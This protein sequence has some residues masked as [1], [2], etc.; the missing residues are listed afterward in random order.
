[1]SHS[2]DNDDYVLADNSAT[3]STVSRH[4]SFLDNDNIDSL[5]PRRRSRLERQSIS[6]IAISDILDPLSPTNENST[7]S[8]SVQHSIRSRANSIS[9]LKSPV[10]NGQP[11]EI[12]HKRVASYCFAFDIDGV[13]LKGPTLIPEAKK[14]IHMLNGNNKYNVIV[15]FIFVTNGGGYDER[16]RS[17]LLSEKL[18]TDIDEFQVVQGHTPMRSLTNKYKNVLVV[19]GLGDNCRQIGLKYGF[20]NVYT[21]SDIIHWNPSVTPYYKLTDDEEELALKDVDFSKINIDCVMIMADSRNWVVDQ[22]IILELLL[23]EKGVMGT[24]IDIK[25]DD[26]PAVIEKKL[27]KTQPDLYFAHS[28]FVWATDYNLTRYGMGALQVSLAA[29][30]KE[31]TNGL[32]LPC[33]RFGKPQRTTFDFCVDFLQDWRKEVLKHISFTTGKR[34]SSISNGNFINQKR[35]Q[36]ITSGTGFK[37]LSSQAA[38]TSIMDNSLDKFR[39]VNFKNNSQAAA[40]RNSVYEAIETEEDLDDLDDFSLDEDK[41]PLSPTA[42]LSPIDELFKKNDVTMEKINKITLEESDDGSASSDSD[43]SVTDPK[44]ALTINKT[45]IQIPPPTTVYFVG[46]TPESDIRFANLHHESWFSI[47]VETGVYQKGTT[48]KYEPKLIRENVLEAV[49]W[50][51]E[52]EHKKECEE[53]LKINNEDVLGV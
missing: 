31:H 23:S 46:D 9:L 14:A 18:E 4:K 49:E 15:P 17:K 21:V 30:Y 7:R 42:K 24:H 37:P 20:E 45:T 53:W 10:S 47:L 44:N 13:I 5:K 39:A 28:D 1:M 35:P 26:D 3:D 43:D 12:T 40:K 36:S 22:Q 19:G 33:K 11:L 41:N 29:L 16:L 52:N 48:P 51:I 2:S 6:N 34:I 32:E 27:Q 50:V 38:N 25:H 8:A